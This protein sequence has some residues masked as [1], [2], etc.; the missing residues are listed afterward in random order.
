M[1]G[2]TMGLGWDGDETGW[3]GRRVWLICGVGTDP[4]GVE[5]SLVST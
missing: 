3:K 2:W 1:D 4:F 5:V